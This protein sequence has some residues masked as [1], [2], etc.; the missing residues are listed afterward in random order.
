MM[1]LDGGTLLVLLFV[2]AGVAV[3]ILVIWNSTRRMHEQ[4]NKVAN[5]QTLIRHD[6]SA[7]ALCR[8]V[9]M[10]QPSVHAGI[11]YMIKHDGSAQEA[12]ISEWHATTTQPTPGELQSITTQMADN[13]LESR[14]AEMRKAEYPSVGD[15]LEAAYLARQGDDSKQI[16]IDEQ[17]RRVKEKYPKVEE[18]L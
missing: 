3:W 4:I 7:R 9:H 6:D 11:D 14:Y 15:Q 17:I 18:C 12:Y 13:N 2:L 10:L 1:S 8:A 5:Q 16:E